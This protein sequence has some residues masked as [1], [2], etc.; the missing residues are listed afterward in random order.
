[1]MTYWKAE[2]WKKKKEEQIQTILSMAF[3]DRWLVHTSLS[4]TI[5]CAKLTRF[6]AIHYLWGFQSANAYITFPIR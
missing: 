2:T 5:P 4:P 1:M 6:L 3:C